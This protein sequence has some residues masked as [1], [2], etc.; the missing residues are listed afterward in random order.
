MN[1]KVVKV[2]EDGITF[3]N[4][5]VLTSYHDRDCCENHWLD[6]SPLSI[7]DFEGLC[8]DLTNE[9]F[10]ER[11]P[12]YGIALVPI[13]GFPVRIAGYGSNNGYYSS[14]MDLVLTFSDKTTTVFDISE[15]QDYDE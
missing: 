14:N 13:S 9:A 12:N 3:E 11:I 10:F 8:F 15:C 6:F 4:G 7:A 2:D 1:M 5:T